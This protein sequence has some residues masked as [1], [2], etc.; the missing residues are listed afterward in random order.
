MVPPNQRG[1]MSLAGFS[2]EFLCLCFLVASLL[3]PFYQMVSFRLNPIIRST[4]S[5]RIQPT[6]GLVLLDQ[7]FCLFYVQEESGDTV[8]KG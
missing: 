8:L 2:C 5:L 7:E 1:K 6:S 3:A 4:R